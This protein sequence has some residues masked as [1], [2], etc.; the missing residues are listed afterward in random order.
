MYQPIPRGPTTYIT[1]RSSDLAICISFR[2]P[3]LPSVAHI[4]VEMKLLPYS[5]E[6]VQDSHLLPFSSNHSST[7][8]ISYSLDVFTIAQIFF[9]YKKLFYPFFLQTI[10]YAWI[11]QD[12]IWI[13]CK[14]I[15]D[16]QT[17][18]LFWDFL[19]SF[20]GFHARKFMIYRQISSF[21][22]FFALFLDFM[23]ENL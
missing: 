1:G 7:P 3:D 11:S 15:Y 16:L 23:P 20:F 2:L 14:K 6:F 13:S 5:D 9:L 22:I 8:V 12:C 4:Y 19:C 21:G 17:N 18:I 10:S